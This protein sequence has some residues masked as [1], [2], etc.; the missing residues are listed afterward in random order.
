MRR[1]LENPS[2]AAGRTH[3]WRTLRMMPGAF[4]GVKVGWLRLFCAR[5]MQ[6]AGGTS[7]D[8][9]MTSTPW[10]APMLTHVAR[11]E[12]SKLHLSTTTHLPCSSAL[13][14]ARAHALR[15]RSVS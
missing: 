15:E 9:A 11:W 6:V 7:S 3:C 1:T 14:A 5:A 10:L 2:A 8:A 4:A 13:L 12:A